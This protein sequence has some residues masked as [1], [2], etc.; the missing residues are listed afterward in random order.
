MGGRE[1]GRKG[2]TYGV[3][4]VG[5]GEG[6]VVAFVEFEALGTVVSCDVGSGLS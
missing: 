1:G 4:A 5:V 2:G 3:E 6:V